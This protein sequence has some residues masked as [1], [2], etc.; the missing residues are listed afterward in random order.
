MNDEVY[1]KKGT[2]FK[3]RYNPSEF[4]IVI[5]LISIYDKYIGRQQIQNEEPTL[6]RTLFF[7]SWSST[8]TSNKS[9]IFRSCFARERTLI[10][11]Q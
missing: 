9:N 10:K 6:G 7:Q 11:W 2:V 3:D 5:T 8:T 4:K 1:F